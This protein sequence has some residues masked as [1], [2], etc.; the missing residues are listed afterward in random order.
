MLFFYLIIF[1]STFF[2]IYHLISAQKFDD[3]KILHPVEQKGISVLIPC[4][5]EAPI[6]KYTVEGLLNVE[7]DHIEVIF[8]NDGSKDDTFQVL[9]GLLDLSIWKPNTPTL[10][11]DKVKGIYKS[12]K[13]PFMYVID[14]Y[15]SG[16]ADSLN[17]GISYA[18]KELIV[19][20]DGDC[21]L[22]KNAL[23]NMNKTFDD[24]EIIASGGV[25]HVMQMFK[26]YDKLKQIV[27]IQ[28]LDYIKGFYIYKASLA[29]NNALSIIS[30]AFA[31]FRKNIIEEIGGFKTVLGEDIDITLRLQDYAKKYN[32]K[33]A[34]NRNAIC[35][36]ECPENLRELISQRIR[37]QKGFIQAILNNTNFLFKNVLKSN[38]CFY[39]IADALLS[40][41]FAS[42]VF[43]INII[44]VLTRVINGYPSYIL[45]YYLSTII[46][47]IICS[48]IAIKNAK[49]NTPHL[50][51]RPLYFMIIFDII[52]FQ[53]LRIFFFLIGT[54]T[55]YFD[56]K[57]W[58]KVNR[59]NNP[60]KV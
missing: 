14:K 56:N 10:T 49:K 38:V 50:K 51:T 5:N 31:V 59:T 57:Q 24:E 47:N 20:M 39:I 44:F 1:V 17:I 35:Y 36:T 48:V 40:N 4:Y 58:Y 9:S 41:S 34:F 15:N 52:F 32:K 21:I 60:Y 54:V 18:S 3:I 6:L 16:K 37:W 13:H 28:G 45:V 46:F 12:N 26:L 7:Y 11:Y 19:T 29:Y 53:F 22:E 23:I 2:S 33:I 43:I 27:L 42:I 55:Y 30:G 8:I 25:I